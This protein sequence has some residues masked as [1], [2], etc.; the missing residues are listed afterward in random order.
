MDSLFGEYGL[1]DD[2]S[3]VLIVQRRQVLAG[4]SGV[5]GAWTQVSEDD[6]ATWAELGPFADDPHADDPA[7]SE[8]AALYGRGIVSRDG[9]MYAGV[10]SRLGGNALYV[11]ETG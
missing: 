7:R 6:G 1:A 8:H 2:G 9:V 10:W 11:S 3:L 5:V 4:D